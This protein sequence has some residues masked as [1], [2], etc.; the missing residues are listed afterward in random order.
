MKKFGRQMVKEGMA[1]GE[2]LKAIRRFVNWLGI[3]QAK[4]RKG[5]DKR[6]TQFSGTENR[7][8]L[9]RLVETRKRIGV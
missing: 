9:R 8:R 6:F 5:F 1:T 2:S 4:E 3:R 7:E